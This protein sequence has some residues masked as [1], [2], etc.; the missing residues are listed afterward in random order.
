LIKRGQ[1]GTAEK[2][3]GREALPGSRSGADRPEWLPR[4][5]GDPEVSRDESSGIRAGGNDRKEKGLG[6]S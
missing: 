6:K 1:N 2:R 3:P 5:L 4:N